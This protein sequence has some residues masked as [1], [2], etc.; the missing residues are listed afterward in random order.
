MSALSHVVECWLFSVN[1]SIW[2]LLTSTGLP[3]HEASII[4]WEISSTRLHKPLLTRSISHSTFS[5]H[6]TNL[7]LHFSGI[8]TFLKIIKHNAETYFLPS[9]ILKW[10]HKN[11]PILIFF[12]CML[13][14]QLT[15]Y[16]LTKLF[17]MKLKTTRC[18]L[19]H[20]CREK[21]KCTFWPTHYS[22]SCHR[23]SSIAAALWCLITSPSK[24]FLTST[25][26]PKLKLSFL[27]QLN[28][29][30]VSPSA[31][32]LR[33][34]CNSHPSSH[35][36]I[37]VPVCKLVFTL[38]LPCSLL[39]SA[40]CRWDPP[41]KSSQWPRHRASGPEGCPSGLGVDASVP[42]GR[43]KACRGSMGGIWA[44]QPERPSFQNQRA[45]ITPY[46]AGHLN[47]ICFLRC[48]SVFKC[49]NQN[50]SGTLQKTCISHSACDASQHAILQERRVQLWP[51]LVPGFYWL[52]HTG[53][54][55]CK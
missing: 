32:F 49:S 13:I 52:P 54:G 9:L 55:G 15:Q 16:N 5:T 35:S 24:S 31:K 40:Q 29:E 7:F 47:W 44:A 3:D 18:Y 23:S 48:H 39:F 28:N 37:N 6:C 10:L 25:L 26:S 30:N 34:V 42:A 19:S 45:K 17:Q 12:K 2:L 43:R 46:R 20:L 14:W 36:T 8:F 1:V 53:L 50:K 38:A 41:E 27:H 21:T 4:Q 33:E 22:W 51:S 11:S